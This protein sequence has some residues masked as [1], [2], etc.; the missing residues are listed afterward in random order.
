MGVLRQYFFDTQGEVWDVEQLKSMLYYQI[1]NFCK[2]TF[3]NGMEV[4][5]LLTLSKMTKEEASEFIT[6]VLDYMESLPDLI[7]PPDL[8]NCWLLHVTAAE[9]QFANEFNFPERDPEYLKYQRSLSCLYSGSFENIEVHHIKSNQYGGM[10]TKPPDWFSIPLSHQVHIGE[11][12]MDGQSK[13]IK[14]LPL[15]GFNI[16]IYCKLAYLRWKFKNN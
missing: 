14:G 12:H 8:R 13:T 11:L 15:Y 6:K 7:I 10:A 2:R 16:E 4:S 1:G 5:E 3:P 9:I